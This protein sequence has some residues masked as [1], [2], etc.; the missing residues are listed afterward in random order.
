MLPSDD[1][2]YTRVTL[3]VYRSW[4]LCSWVF[5]RPVPQDGLPT[6]ALFDLSSPRD[7]GGVDK[8]YSQFLRL[9]N[10][11]KVQT[12]LA[13]WFGTRNYRGLGTKKGGL[14]RLSSQTQDSGI[15]RFAMNDLGVGQQ[16]LARNLL[17]V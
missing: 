12:N 11:F 15:S 14:R 8:E 2:F 6:T 13:R 1:I 10:K 7:N 5:F 4:V 16:Q 9:E 3:L 17:Y